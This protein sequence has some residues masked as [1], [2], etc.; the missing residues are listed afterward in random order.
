MKVLVAC[1]YSGRVRDAF[2]AKGHDAISCDLLETEVPGKHYQGDIKD[3]IFD[4]FDLMIAHP[5]C[6]HLAVS[7]SRHFWRKEKEQKEAL[8]FVR[9]LMDAPIKRWCLEN[10]V[11]VISSRIR[12][13]DQTIQPYMFGHGETK[14]TCF[15]LKNLP[16]LKPTKYVE[17]R[18]PKVWLEP[19]GPDRWKNRS[20]TYQGIADAMAEQ[21]GDESR[22][23]TPVEQLTLFS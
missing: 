23:P 3:I 10:P 7:G 19:P 13:S 22:L 21:W 18:E 2:T 16:L 11:S 20:R 12:P 17:G 4:G 14:A 6:T 8:D 15:W 9:F 5:P 1:E